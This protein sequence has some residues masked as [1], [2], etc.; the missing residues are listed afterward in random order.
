MNRKNTQ[1]LVLAC[2]ALVLSACGNRGDL[3][4][5]QDEPQNNSQQE[6]TLQK[7]G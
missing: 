6:D 1:W 2:L 5:P 7:D 3:Y 4:I